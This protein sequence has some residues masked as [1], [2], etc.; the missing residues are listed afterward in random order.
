MSGVFLCAPKDFRASQGRSMG[1]Q[2]YSSGFQGRSRD[3][4]CHYT[5][6]RV[7]IFRKT[8]AFQ[9]AS[10]MFQGISGAPE[11]FQDVS[12]AFQGSFRA[13]L[14]VFIGFPE[15]LGGFGRG[16]WDV[17]GCSSRFHER[18]RGLQGVSGV[19]KGDSGVFHGVSGSFRGTYEISVAFQD[20]SKAFQG[21]S[22][23]LRKVS[24]LFQGLSGMY[25]GG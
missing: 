11:V 21:V 15:R 6:F 22:G 4:K 8:R 7:G 3:L 2:R 9:G 24:G 16:W 10:G 18:F 25:H 19:F 12:W 20:I 1:F 17:P 13:V 23:A 5:V 14:A